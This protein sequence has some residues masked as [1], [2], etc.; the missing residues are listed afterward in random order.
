M[1]RVLD[2]KMVDSKIVAS[3]VQELQVISHEIQAEG[4]TLS[5]TF[6]V[7]TI[8]EKLSPAWKD[9]KNYLRHKRQEMSIEDLIIRHHIE[10]NNK[11]SGKTVTHNSSEAKANFVEL[12]QSSK[13]KKGN[14]NGKNTKMGPRKEISQR[15]KSL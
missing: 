13:F 3:Q 11:G 4:M 12:G 5:Q 1:G 15:N 7:T 10:E 9:F 8:I 6:Q 2:Y 14:N